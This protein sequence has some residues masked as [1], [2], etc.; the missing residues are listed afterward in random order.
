MSL[1]LGNVEA[2]DHS[3]IVREVHRILESQAGDYAR[4]LDLPFEERHDLQTIQTRYRRLMRLLHPDKRSKEDEVL[5][6]GRENCDTALQIVQEACSLAK[7]DADSRPR[8]KP[9]EVH[10]RLQE[11]QRQQARQAMQRTLGPPSID[12]LLEAR[13]HQAPHQ[14][15]MPECVTPQVARG[16]SANTGQRSTTTCRNMSGDGF[17]KPNL[18]ALLSDI[19]E[20]MTSS[21]A[22]HAEPP[23]SES[24]VSVTSQIINLLAEVRNR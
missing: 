3:Q 11:I 15:G 6:G 18:D 14:A 9:S 4:I 10:L 13:H 22:S 5:V 7:Q 17:A 19:T 2:E 8:P 24:G 20:V 21:Q 1:Q 23:P 16:S 12:P